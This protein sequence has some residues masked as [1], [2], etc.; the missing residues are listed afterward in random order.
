[1]SD[2]FGKIKK[3]YYKKILKKEFKESYYSIKTAKTKDVIKY[4]LFQR[5]YYAFILI[6]VLG[7]TLFGLY[8][9]ANRRLENYVVQ[10][11]AGALQEIE[12]YNNFD[13][14]LATN[15]NKLNQSINPSE[16]SSKIQTMDKR[17]FVFNQYFKQRSS[18][19]MGLGHLFTNACDKYGA[20]KDCLAT[21]AIAR[22]ET[23]LCK[24]NISAQM[25]NC[26]GWGGAGANRMT[27]P[28]F[29]A[30]IDT[31]TRVL[32]QQYG[33]DRMVDPSLMETVFCG[34]Q[35]ECKAW[36]Y[37]VKVFMEEI[38][39]LAVSLGVG[40]LSDLRNK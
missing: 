36:G 20:P 15:T 16:Y 10:A 22:H 28:S 8:S 2:S 40:K 18:P 13:N 14:A 30:H 31:A 23:D 33:P 29:E 25:H 38:D 5:H 12:T 39:D 11:S 32:V 7:I 4:F 37:R 3:R 24:Y 26:M 34:P 9:N 35:D 6:I 21:V 27:F 1:M 19:L 17:E